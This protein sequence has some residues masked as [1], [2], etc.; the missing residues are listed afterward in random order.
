M[1]QFEIIP[2]TLR[3]QFDAGTSRGVLR[4]KKTWFLKLWH[5]DF[6]GR[7]G[8]GEAGLLEG[9]SPE[10]P[11]TFESDFQ[12]LS[13]KLTRSIPTHLSSW[14]KL[15]ANL[16]K[17]WEGPWLPSAWF[18]WETAFLDWANGGN[19]L[20]CDALF[21]S[22]AWAVP[23]NG[24]VWMNTRSQMEVQADQKLQTGFQA[25]KFKVGALQWEEEW[26]MIQQ[27]RGQNPDVS[28]RLDANGAW[29]PE[30]ALQKLEQLSHLQIHSVEQPIAV[31]NVEVM[32]RLCIESPVPIALDEELINHPYDHQKYTLLEKIVPAF[33]VLKPSLVGGLGQSHQWIKMAEDLGIEWWITSMLESNIGLNSI[34]QLAAQYRPVLPQGLGTGQLYV[35]NIASPL[36]VENGTIFRDITQNW[37]P[38]EIPK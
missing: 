19:R 6:P 34:C 13:Q 16:M 21:H 20:I 12:Q 25:I 8:W 9:L 7:L 27:F 33:I 31:G 15:S 23:I 1:F 18:A 11:A 4:E 35:N 26:A 3:F 22:G 14:E 28:I 24:L 38:V 10:N 36:K 37:D 30:E 29:Q 2:Y 32:S 5:P 17:H